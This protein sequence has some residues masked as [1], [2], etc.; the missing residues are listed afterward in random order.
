[1]EGEVASQHGQALAEPGPQKQRRR[2]GSATRTDHDHLRPHPVFSLFP[3]RRP[4]EARGGD[5]SVNRP[6]SDRGDPTVGDHLDTLRL[7][8]RQLHHV[9]A[10]FGLV[11]AAEVAQARRPAAFD[12]DG[13]LLHPVAEFAAAVG[14]QPVVVIDQIFVQKVDVVLLDVL[15]R[16]RVNIREIEPG[17]MPPFDDLFGHGQRG[18]G[19]DHGRPTVRPPR[20]QGHRPVAGEGA[21]GIDVEL[22]DH[23]EFASGEFVGLEPG[24]PLENRDANARGAQG[25]QFPG[26]RATARPGADDDDV[27][28]VLTHGDRP[29]RQTPGDTRRGCWSPVGRNSP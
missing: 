9:G 10:L 28:F 8:L 15:H 25:C 13:K 20:G 19:V 7:R 1:M 12:V 5:D 23:F 26:R 11:G 21:A 29:D 16:P 3:S 24:A 17:H 14:E 18:P 22:L 4:A 2:A 27:V 6:V